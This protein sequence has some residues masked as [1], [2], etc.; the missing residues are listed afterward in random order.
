MIKP[1]RVL[2]RLPPGQ[3]I[4]D[5]LFDELRYGDSGIAA[6]VNSF[7]NAAALQEA[8]ENHIVRNT[9]RGHRHV[10]WLMYDAYR[11][12]QEV[13]RKRLRDAEAELEWSRTIARADKIQVYSRRQ[14]QRQGRKYG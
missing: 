14:K 3:F 4:T 10:A 1:V 8:C 11:K 2:K 13:S 7:N 5:E 6:W 12:Q 9:I